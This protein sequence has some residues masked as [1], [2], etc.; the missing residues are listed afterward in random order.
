MKI[1]EVCLFS[2]F[3]F[4]LRLPPL[5]VIRGIQFISCKFLTYLIMRITNISPFPFFFY[6][7]FQSYHLPTSYLTQRFYHPTSVIFSRTSLPLLQ[8]YILSCFI[9][10]YLRLIKSDVTSSSLPCLYLSAV[11]S[12]LNLA[13]QS[14]DHLL[15]CPPNSGLEMNRALS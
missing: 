15:L 10:D 13:S 1:I 9:C 12:P 5:K 7:P 11:M 6:F 3:F 8:K 2:F 4:F 14:R